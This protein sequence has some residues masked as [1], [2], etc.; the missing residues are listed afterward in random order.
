MART[1]SPR[2]RP[3]LLEAA[4][5]LFYSRG[6]AATAVDDIADVAGLT[7]PTLYRHFPSKDAL[8]ANYLDGRHEQLD[9]ELRAW[10]DAAAPSKRPAAVIEWLCDWISRRDFDGCA[11]VR[12]HAELHDDAEVLAKARRRKRVL[13][14][15]IE[16]ACR[17]AGV[18]DPANLADQLTLIV[19]GA[20]T[21]AFISGDPRR[22]A[23]TA[24]QLARGALAIATR[25]QT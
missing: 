8:V 19:E 24:R 12:S 3:A 6:I 13:R 15:T 4:A 9:L 7:K 22:A 20:T 1:I 16:E 23:A 21:T 18:R 10:L 5:R 11:F 14:D 17:D 2:T 25:S